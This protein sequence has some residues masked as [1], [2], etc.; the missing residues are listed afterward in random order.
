MEKIQ[1]VSKLEILLANINTRSC[2]EKI[3]DFVN[4]IDI[5][6]N[7]GFRSINESLILKLRINDELDDYYITA[8]S[9]LKE[10]VLNKIKVENQFSLKTGI[11]KTQPDKM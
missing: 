2:K 1:A 3:D 10:I 9:F 8:S 6:H 5:I 11:Y 7:I 4:I